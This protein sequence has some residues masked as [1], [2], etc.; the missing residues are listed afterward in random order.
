MKVVLVGAGGKM[1]C[2]LTDNFL[3]S[4]KFEVSYLEISDAGTERYR[5][6]QELLH[7]HP[8]LLH[9]PKW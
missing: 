6:Q 9:H 2:R 8:V 4:N 5:E 3:K 7:Q 1:G